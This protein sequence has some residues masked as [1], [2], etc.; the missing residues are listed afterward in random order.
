MGWFP[1]TKKKKTKKTGIEKQIC[2]EMG[3]KKINLSMYS[4][5]MHVL[6]TRK[7]FVLRLQISLQRGKSICKCHFLIFLTDHFFE[8]KKKKKILIVFDNTQ[9]TKHAS[10]S[11]FSSQGP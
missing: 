10:F 1:K 9:Q 7:I 8:M 3:L 11:P 4:I 5:E 2:F 6:S